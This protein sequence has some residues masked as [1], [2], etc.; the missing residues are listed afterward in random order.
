MEGWVQIEGNTQ[1]RVLEE[2]AG[3]AYSKLPEVIRDEGKAHD[4]RLGFREVTSPIMR[5]EFTDNDVISRVLIVV[6]TTKRLASYY[7]TTMILEFEIIP[8][9]QHSLQFVT[10]NNDLI[11]TV[12]IMYV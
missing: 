5:D 12:Y 10:E 3:I 7:K 9:F 6:V 11:Y 8:N 1:L 4:V 2:I